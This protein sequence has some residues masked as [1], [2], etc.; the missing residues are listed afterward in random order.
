MGV[1]QE[2]KRTRDTMELHYVNFDPCRDQNQHILAIF[3]FNFGLIFLN[4]S[5]SN[6]AALHRLFC[7]YCKCICRYFLVWTPG[8]LAV[9]KNPNRWQDNIGLN[10]WLVVIDS[11]GVVNIIF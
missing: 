11:R 8:G 9:A 10:F 3:C 6:S 7:M 1:S 4:L 5:L 2:T